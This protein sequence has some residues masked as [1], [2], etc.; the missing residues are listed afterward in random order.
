[1]KNIHSSNS[2]NMWSSSEQI[3]YTLNG[4]TYTNYLGNYWSDYTGEDKDRDG[5]GDD[6]YGIDGDKDYYP[7][8]EPLVRYFEEQAQGQKPTPAPTP[9][10]TFTGEE[11]WH[12]VVTFTGAGGQTTPSFVIRGDEWRVK[13]TVIVSAT[14]SFFNVHVLPKGKT[15][16]TVAEWNWD[17]KYS[18]SDIQYIHKGNGSYYFDVLVMNID[19]WELIVEDYY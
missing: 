5:I 14:W 15:S 13:W 10:P 18:Y 7:M 12:S 3:N 6:S 2:C 11:A 9:T 17:K 8:M 1:M 16:E 4:I 19:G